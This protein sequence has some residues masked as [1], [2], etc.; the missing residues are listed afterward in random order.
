MRIIE[1]SF[2]MTQ[3]TNKSIRIAVLFVFVSLFSASGMC[4]FAT[5]STG[6][7]YNT[8]LYGI[9]LG[10]TLNQFIEY[11]REN[12]LVYS[13]KEKV[14]FL[15]AED[16]NNDYPYVKYVAPSDIIDEIHF[17]K[18]NASI[19]R[20]HVSMYKHGLGLEERREQNGNIISVYIDKSGNFYAAFKSI[21]NEG[22]L[23]GALWSADKF[24]S[25]YG[26][27]DT[28]SKNKNIKF[29]LED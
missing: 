28:V 25:L 4:W 27:Y 12:G 20:Q 26:K 1:V 15:N 14:C 11:C 19:E 22:P 29:L 9:K 8:G 21:G 18:E 24:Q 16:L 13:C 23:F 7:S 10:D 17:V 5:P 3:T 6:K 2:Y